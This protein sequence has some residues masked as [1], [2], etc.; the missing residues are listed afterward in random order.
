[1]RIENAS[2]VLTNKHGN[3][4]HLCMN[5]V[6]LHGKY[7]NERDLRPCS[8]HSDRFTFYIEIPLWLA[9]L[10]G[11]DWRYKNKKDG[12]CLLLLVPSKSESDVKYCW[13]YIRNYWILKS[14]GMESFANF[15]ST[16][17]KKYSE[18]PLGGMTGEQATEKLSDLLD[19]LRAK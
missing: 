10:Y 4:V 13:E 17:N 9:K 15:L 18:F 19:K 14:N 8:F 6:Y 3:E 5:D 12:F 7:F 16:G 11:L 2:L 1:M